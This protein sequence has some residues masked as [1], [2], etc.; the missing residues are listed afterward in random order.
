MCVLFKA[1]DTA[2]IEQYRLYRCPENTELKID[3]DYRQE[4]SLTMQNKIYQVPRKNMYIST[5]QAYKKNIH[6]IHESNDNLI[7]VRN[8]GKIGEKH[9]RVD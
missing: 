3:Y 6:V 1:R 2:A 4:G 8:C 5:E 7:I 9:C